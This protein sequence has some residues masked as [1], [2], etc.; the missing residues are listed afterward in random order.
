MWRQ[1]ILTA[2]ITAA[3]LGSAGAALAQDAGDPIADRIIEFLQQQR[4]QA[5]APELER[6]AE[7]DAVARQRAKQIAALPHKKRLSLGEPIEKRLEEANIRLYRRAS[8]HMDM[9][10]G[11]ADAGGAFLRSWRNYS[12]AWAKALDERFDGVGIATHRAEDDWLVLVAVFLEDLP[13]HGDLRELELRTIRLVNDL[14]REHGLSQLNEL[15]S[16]S[17]VARAHSEDM[18][19]RGYFRHVSPEGHK[20]EDRVRAGGLRYRSLAENIQLNRGWE[21]PAR[22]AVDAWLDS[23]GHREAM[24]A[25]EF[26]E[27]GVGVSLAEDG[28][29]YFTQ[30]FILRRSPR[31]DA[32]EEPATP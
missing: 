18:A 30:L 14:R 17:A 20:A 5:G 28:T 13:G 8:T 32:D 25:P 15:E 19:R 7:L 10:R 3:V 12:Q 23:P 27:T 4:I 2:A 22:K 31:P 29:L 1:A 6:R 11:Y 26:L 9:N 21:E 24:L 16:L